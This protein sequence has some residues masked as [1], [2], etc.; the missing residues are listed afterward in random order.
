MGIQEREI[1]HMETLV[2]ELRIKK[3]ELNNA[4][5]EGY[6]WGEIQKEIQ[7]IRKELSDLASRKLLLV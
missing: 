7:D 4:Y 6:E 5:Y 1:K 3:L 2:E